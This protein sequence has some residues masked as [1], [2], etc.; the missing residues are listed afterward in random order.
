MRHPSIGFG[1][2][3]L[4]H[5]LVIA[6]GAFL[7]VSPPQFAVETGHDSVEVNLVAAA[8]EQ[9]TAS[10]PIP[11]PV[12]EVPTPEPPK[13]D[14]MVVPATPP[15]PPPP[16]TTPP[17][18]KP[19]EKPTPPTP[20]PPKPQ[21]TRTVEKG[22]SSA[23]KPG[24]DAVTASSD[25]GAISEAKPDYL[26]N[27]PPIYPEEARHRKQQGVVT[28]EVTVDVEGRPDDISI[29]TSSGYQILDQAAVNAVHK[30]RF[31]P[32]MMGSIKIKSRV[33]IPVHFNLEG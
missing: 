1:I 31:R 19:V 25:G 22:D 16:T 18:E 8:P 9:V 26:R 6:L 23:P 21:T 28:L 4:I 15:I 12:P 14:D 2:S 13:P 24:K 29:A 32:A 20:Q 27:P 11:E 30:W 7:I 5:L 33:L 3:A 10:P 17:P